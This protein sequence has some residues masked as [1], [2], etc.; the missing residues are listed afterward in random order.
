MAKKPATVL[1]MTIRIAFLA[2]FAP[3]FAYL[4]VGPIV[5]IKV[6]A[7]LTAAVLA[8]PVTLGIY[9]QIKLRRRLTHEKAS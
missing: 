3:A 7:C 5:S 4:L 9:Q 6:W 8:L 2:V 1:G